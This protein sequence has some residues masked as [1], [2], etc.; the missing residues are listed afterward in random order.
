MSS[1]PGT[2]QF[3]NFAA[4]A[5]GT[6]AGRTLA[7]GNGLTYAALNSLFI[8]YV[9][10]ATVGNRIPIFRVQAPITLANPALVTLWQGAFAAVTAGQTSLL[11]AGSG[12][13]AS[14]VASPLMQFV[15]LPFDI[16][17]PLNAQVQIFDS[18]NVD[19][20]D[21]VALVANLAK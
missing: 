5:L 10:S 17:L 16:P 15:T 13:P 3:A 4:A 11:L 8:T 6:A 9:A 2:P 18:A 19:T 14:V 12:V 7:L 21:T 1:R 20:A